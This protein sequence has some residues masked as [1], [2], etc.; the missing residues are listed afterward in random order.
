MALGS[1]RRGRARTLGVLALVVALVCSVSAT[2]YLTLEA[3]EER[4]VSVAAA[5]IRL[6]VLAIAPVNE[7]ESL[8]DAN[9]ALFEDAVEVLGS[10]V[11]TALHAVDPD[12]QDEIKQEIDQLRRHGVMLTSG[13]AMPHR[14]HSI[15]THQTLQ[16]S[17]RDASIAATE[18]ARTAERQA[19]MSGL[20]SLALI[21]ALMAVQFRSRTRASAIQATADAYRGAADRFG[22]LLEQ[23]PD[24]TAVIAEDGTVA[25]ASAS[26]SALLG[27][28]PRTA[29][30]LSALVD[31]EQRAA[32]VEHLGSRSTEPVK[33][34][35]S[36]VDSDE[37]Q[38]REFSV[39]VADLRSDPVV[40]GHLVTVAETTMQNRSR[41]QLEQLARHDQ[42]TGL[43]NRRALIERLTDHPPQALL[44][45]DLD[46][47]KETND[48]LGHAA[49]DELLIAVARRFE[50]TVGTGGTVHRL[51]G[52]EFA[53]LF[54]GNLQATNDLAA[55]LVAAAA[56]PIPLSMGF[57]RASISVGIAHESI[58]SST[59]PLLRRADIALHEAKREG[60]H[61]T[62]I[63]DDELEA[64]AVHGADISRSFERADFDA[65]L[66]LAFQAIVRASDHEPVLVEALARWTS[67]IH[68]VVRPDVFIGLAES[69]GRIVELGE[70]VI[71]RALAALV[72]LR[73][74]G[75]GTDVRMSV[76]VSPFQL[77]DDRFVTYTAARLAE[78]GVEPSALVIELTES[79]LVADDER[80]L[81]RLRDLGALGCMIACDDFGS[82][83]SNLGQ[84]MKLPI[85]L[86]KV[87][88]QLLL[89][90]GEMRAHTGDNSQPCQVM[91]AIASIGD[92]MQAMIVAEG[93]ETAEQA[94]SLRDSGVQ[95]LQGYLFSRPLPLDGIRSLLAERDA[96]AV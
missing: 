27:R 35:V 57:E 51:G 40:N 82:G 42:L 28:V 11:G 5:D 73:A 95:Y 88:R 80:V 92:A 91:T 34:D 60:G 84:L 94:V 44:M 81:R 4:Q 63:A 69:S 55:R 67:P 16:A 56:T 38:A 8:D 50:E 6:A 43:P 65:E 53:V 7:V 68:G 46:S 10:D 54:D 72:K 37:D 33:L 62:R 87:D 90:L 79:A 64:S 61:T 31:D 2:L 13:L 15:A 76:N 17:M 12:E 77:I 21:G 26:M 78:N 48:T 36:L 96:V 86:I 70:W 32:L 14:H 24:A 39:R 3:L 49:G 9:R 85:S 23:S 45:L 93:V 30:D 74:D 71:D 75:A 19:T 25:Y 66:H 1:P 83:Y 20:A 89:T 58:G 22:A 18:S 59:L 29:E 52:D 41:R 47:F